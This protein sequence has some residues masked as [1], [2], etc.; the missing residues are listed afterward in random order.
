MF[1]FHDCIY[2]TFLPPVGVIHAK[3]FVLPVHLVIYKSDSDLTS[4]SGF[5][6]SIAF[7]FHMQAS[8]YD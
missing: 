7:F 5:R 1:Y 2:L 3:F 6:V 8:S 4:H